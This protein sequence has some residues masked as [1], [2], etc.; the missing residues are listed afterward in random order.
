MHIQIANNVINVMTMYIIF[1]IYIFLL[2]TSSFYRGKMV[3]HFMKKNKLIFF[4][5]N[6]LGHILCRGVSLH[7]L[8]H[9]PSRLPI[10]G[11]RLQTDRHVKILLELYNKRFLCTC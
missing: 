6:C 1:I 5:V 9:I 11:Y 4:L 7:Q 8:R 10:N 3:E 2:I